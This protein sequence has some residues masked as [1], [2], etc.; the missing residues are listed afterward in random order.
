MA[1]TFGTSN[2]QKPTP[3]FWRNAGDGIMVL[4]AGLI[5]MI[6]ALP[7]DDSFKLWAVPILV[8][9]GFIGKWVTKLFGSDTPS[10][11]T[12]TT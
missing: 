3:K 11:N 6:T 7:V 5:T 1:T 10:D 4:S 8:Y 2:W 9:V 12:P